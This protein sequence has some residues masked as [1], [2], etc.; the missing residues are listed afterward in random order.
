MSWN[1]ETFSKLRRN[2]SFGGTPMK[3]QAILDRGTPHCRRTFNHHQDSARE[4]GKIIRFPESSMSYPAR[5][6]EFYPYKLQSLHP[7]DNGISFSK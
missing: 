2:T 3:L 7:I 4:T 1:T 6:L 5:N